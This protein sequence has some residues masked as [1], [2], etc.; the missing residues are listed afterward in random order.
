[1]Y[2]TI[3]AATTIDSEAVVNCNTGNNFPMGQ[4][5]QQ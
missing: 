3:G 4:L 2:E 5:W 1:M